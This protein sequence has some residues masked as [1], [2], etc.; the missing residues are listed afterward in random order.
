M[1]TY[2]S[3]TLAPSESYILPAGATILS[4]SN[5][6]IYLSENGCAP[7]DNVEPLTCYGFILAVRSDNRPN[8]SQ[9]YDMDEDTRY[10]GVYLNGVFYPFGS[11]PLTWGGSGPTIY[12]AFSSLPFS[13]VLL[14]V[15]ASAASDGF[16]NST[17]NY[18][19][20]KT[21]ASIGDNLE[22]RAVIDAADSSGIPSVEFRI[23]CKTRASIV[24]DGNANVVDC[25][26]TT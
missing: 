8:R 16:R 26:T 2:K 5:S 21:F 24:S 19:I 25:P 3:V 7:L 15:T 22:L 13:S 12:D 23:P 18:I 20:F 10:D 17:K 4:V 14:G 11:G 9:P 1:P 6:A